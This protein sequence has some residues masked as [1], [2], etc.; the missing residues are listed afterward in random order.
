MNVA[1]VLR[2]RIRQ[3]RNVLL[4]RSPAAGRTGRGR[5]AGV[6]LTLGFAVVLWFGLRAFFG[7]L[8]AGGLGAEEA[9]V[10]LSLLLAAGLAALLVFDLQEA[11][12]V[13]LLDSDLEL[14]R[15]APLSPRSLFLLKLADALIATSTLILVFL[16]PALIA[17]GV[18]YRLPGWAWALIPVQLGALWT[19]PLGA[20][21]ALALLGV[22]RLPV[23][24]AR[25]RLALLSTLTLTLAWLANAFLLPRLGG[26]D[27]SLPDSLARLAARPAGLAWAS[28]TIWAARSLAA[29]ARGDSAAAVW[30][31][32]VLAG[33][34]ALALGFA[35]WVAGHALEPAQLRVSTPAARRGGRARAVP[36]ELPSRR[37]GGVHA[38]I[39]RRDRLLFIRDWTVLTDVFTG[40][41]LWT[42][43]PLV[44]MP[45]R[46]APEPWIVRSMLVT[47][48]VALGY[49]V[50]ARAL[51]FERGGGAWLRLAPVPAG[52]W[53]AA[54]LAGATAL[55]LPLLLLA[56]VT[57]ALAFRIPAAEW[58]GILSLALPALGLA[59]A[60][61]LM[62]GA[63][64]G[65]PAW[66]NPRAM[67]KL[68]GRLL[69]SLLL[70]LQVTLW[71][72]LA[73]AAHALRALLPRA[74]VLGGPALLA[75][76]LAVLPL[77]AAAR[78]LERAEWQA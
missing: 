70:I 16:A 39:L 73:L 27:G 50:A 72:G 62:N 78:R 11:V 43:L 68:P 38:A 45:H 63:A 51:P 20:G 57:L 49:E 66:T 1:G 76:G 67:L 9:A 10:L 6:V 40:S 42:L 65:D 77:R 52:R 74:L 75:L 21:V 2:G 60:L 14:L 71:I 47:L 4:G 22:S 30:N 46:A 3:A 17:Y 53:L 12:S 58:I 69:A 25:E 33:A 15:V 48:A 7:H 28:P 13:L 41:L 55:A 23:R 18:I 8:A 61:G 35:A 44:A 54:K 34:G 36:C 19:I 24:R 29:A 32:A 37:R 56:A 26:P 59:L 64:F 5:R 31:A